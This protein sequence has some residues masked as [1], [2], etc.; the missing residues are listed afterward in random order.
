MSEQKSKAKKI[1]IGSLLL[2]LGTWIILTIL[3]DKLWYPMALHREDRFNAHQLH[4]YL[5]LKNYIEHNGK[6]PSKLED[7]KSIPDKFHYIE[8]YPTAWN[9][10]DQVLFKVQ[11]AGLHFITF[12]DGRSATLTWLSESKIDKGVQ[13]IAP[14]GPPY[15]SRVIVHGITA[16]LITSFFSY[17]KLKKL[18]LKPY[19]GKDHIES[20][21]NET[22][23]QFQ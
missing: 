22:N 13:R 14:L 9:N 2:S 19:L 17:K 12:G 18:F 4:T 7:V 16:I 11:N 6:I 23:R 3:I 5:G 10:P 20:T 21:D 8:Y 1:M 15:T